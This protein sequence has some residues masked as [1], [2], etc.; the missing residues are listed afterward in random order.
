MDEERKYS[1]PARH[2]LVLDNIDSVQEEEN[3]SG[4]GDDIHHVNNVAR[5]ALRE[6]SFGTSENQVN[7]EDVAADEKPVCECSFCHNMILLEDLIAHE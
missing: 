7:H 1:A 4:Q 5:G 2:V 3:S 6:S